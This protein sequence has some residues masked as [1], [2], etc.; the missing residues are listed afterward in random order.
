EA[1]MKKAKPP[2]EK[3]ADQAEH[4]LLQ[5]MTKALEEQSIGKLRLSAEEEKIIRPFQLLTLKPELVMVNIGDDRIGKPLPTD[6]LQLAPTALA[7]P[8]K[9]ELEL[10]ELSPEDR[11]AFMKDLGVT[12]FSRDQTL[13]TIYAGM[14][15]VVFFTIGED[16]CRAWGIPK[17]SDAVTGAGC[18]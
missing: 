15:Q 14:G 12:G 16:E 5:R 1:Q 2:K 10:E 9:L 8:A 3:E 13:H 17:G 4:A 11:E 6:L 7:A 18:I